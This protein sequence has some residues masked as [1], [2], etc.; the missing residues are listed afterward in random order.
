MTVHH[1][2]AQSQ[3]LAAQ[4]ERISKSGL[5]T[6]L[7]CE[8][9]HRLQVEVVVQVQVVEVLSVN[10]QVQH[11]VALPAHLETNFYPV[12]LCRLEEFGSLERTEQVSKIDR[13]KG[14]EKGK[15]SLNA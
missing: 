1:K 9:F 3:N 8:G 14:K 10:Q 6:F 4:V 7:C 11:V 13:R 2:L 15:S 5:L 12:Q